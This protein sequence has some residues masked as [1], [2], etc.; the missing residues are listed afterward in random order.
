MK[1]AAIYAR[2]SSDMQKKEGT[3]Q[4]Q[5]AELHRQIKAAGD[6]LAK[7]YVDEG[8]S[9]ATLDRPGMNEL[10]QDLKKGI[11][12]VIYALN[13][14]RISR[15]AMHLN[16]VITEF[17]IYRKQ[18]IING[19][20]YMNS[21]EN[22][23]EL[24]ILGAVAELE[25]AK[26]MERNQ[27]GRMHK[28]QQGQL[29]G[30][31]LFGYIY[32]P[33]TVESSPKLEID[34]VN[35]KFV[36]FIFEAYVR[37]NTSATEIARHLREFGV[38][39]ETI[40]ME[41]CRVRYILN[42]PTYS[43]TR[44]FNRLTD[45]K[46][47]DGKRATIERERSEWIGVP[48]PAIVSKELFEKVRERL[49]YNRECYR[50][51]R[52][53]QPLSNLIFCAKCKR[54]CPSFRKFYAVKR[55]KGETYYK[56]H[57]FQCNTH[58]ENHNPQIDIRLL[59]SCVREIL[60]ETVFK[61]TELIKHLDF[62]KR[63]V[64]GSKKI[65]KQIIE[66]T[67]KMRDLENQ[68]GRIVDLYAGSGLE[69][70]EY[71]KRMTR[72][73]DQMDILQT[74]KKSLLRQLPLFEDPKLV[75]RCVEAYC[76]KIQNQYENCTDSTSWR[77]F[78]LEF[79]KRVEYDKSHAAAVHISFHGSLPINLVVEGV[80]EHVEVSFTIRQNLSASE[81]A[82]RL[83]E[84]DFEDRSILGSPISKSTYLEVAKEIV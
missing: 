65:E 1:R 21:P 34:E 30:G 49:K 83:R 59:E 69:Q 36:R 46:N 45:R 41:V 72:F 18:V 53:T 13:I 33:R 66:V 38:K 8:H 42:N 10:R 35:A 81:A 24:T 79:V 27:R 4:S 52:G 74:E 71:Y 7:E 64:T 25:R 31:K 44:Y 20:D 48:V 50:N 9:G 32:Y 60:T 26:I 37:G 63:K 40:D 82:L 28:L 16:I 54:R 2:V 80:Q 57:Y 70:E 23:F 5:V 3:I 76:S 55:L 11:Y 6:V 75:G 47:N 68:K 62:F 61:P 84:F 14:D 43:G 29:V 51:A 78:Y 77:E 39:G 22:K 17:L 12:D 19:K 58:G 73:N 56:R 67:Q 15:D